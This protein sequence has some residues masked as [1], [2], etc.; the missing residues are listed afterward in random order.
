MAAIVAL[1]GVMSTALLISVLAQKLLLTRWEK[2]VHNFVLNIELAKNRKHHAADVIKFAI[3]TWYLK[4]KGKH[5]SLQ[6]IRVQ[7][8]LVRS[9][10]VLRQVKHEQRKLIDNCLVLADMFHLQRTGHD[11]I[12]QVQEDM[13]TMKVSVDKLDEK[14]NGIQRTLTHM[15]DAL[16][17]IMEQRAS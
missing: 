17:L 4:R 12:E 5:L 13:S 10:G 15:Q 16:V 7:W 9:I 11:R 8:K 1:I 6:N 3:K 14:F 2:Y